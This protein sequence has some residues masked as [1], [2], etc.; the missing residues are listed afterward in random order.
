MRTQRS[1]SEKGLNLVGWAEKPR[2]CAGGG[3][4]LPSASLS[5]PRWTHLMA[6]EIAGFW[7]SR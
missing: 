4:P 7:A 1:A 2:S 6:G 3:G 5:S